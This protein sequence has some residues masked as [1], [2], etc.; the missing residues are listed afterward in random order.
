MKKMK[1]LIPLFLVLICTSCKEKDKNNDFPLKDTKWKLIGFVDT[2]TDVVTEADPKNCEECYTIT[3]D[4]QGQASAK[5]VNKYRAIDIFNPLGL[6]NDDMAEDIGDSM[7][8][9]SAILHIT[10]YTFENE[11]LKL[12]YEDKENNKNYLLYKLIKS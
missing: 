12:F 7:L 10:S 8:Y 9:D 3:F 2:K 6:E 11:I 4:F 1:F 5:L